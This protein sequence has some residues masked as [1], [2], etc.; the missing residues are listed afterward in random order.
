MIS[1]D[2]VPT[3]EAAKT[4]DQFFEPGG[5]LEQHCTAGGI[6]YELRPQQ[7]KM[8][9]AIADAAGFGHHLAVEAGTGVGK[10]FAYLVPQ[11]LSALEHETRCVIATYTITL[12]EQ[13][14]HKDIP[15]VRQV[16]GREFK[17]V[18]VKGRSNYLCLLRLQR[19]RR[20]GSDLFDSSK[21]S[22]L[23]AIYALASNRQLGDGSLQELAEQPDHQVWG[24]ICAEHG[25][26]TGKRCPFYKECYFMNA[27]QAMMDAQVL[28][29][30]HSLFFAELAL[31]AEGAAML[32]PYG[33]VVF[34][35]AHQMEQVASS[36]LGIRLSLYMLEYWLRRIYIADKNKGLCAVLKDGKGA[37]LATQTSEAA[38]LFF[39]NVRKHFKLGA[40]KT[41]QCVAEP[42]PIDTDLPLKIT[43]LCHHLQTLVQTTDNE[44]IQAEIKSSRNRGLELR[45]TVEAF[46][47]QSLEGQVYWVELQGRNKQAVLYSAP[48]DV[49]PILREMLFEEI[50]C[51]V[52]TSATLAVGNNLEYFRH[53]IGAEECAE[54]QV[55]SPFD[56]SRQMKIQLPTN[57]PPPAAP[58]FEEAA[59]TAIRHFVGESR[60]RAFVLFTNA[61]FMKKVADELRFGFEL[62]GFEFLVQGA[63]MPPQLMLEKFRNHD[64]AV[65]FGLDRFWMGVD[66]QGEALSN[67]IITRLPF[68]VPDHPLIQ[69]RFEAIEARGGNPFK[70]YSLPEAVL[71]FRQGVGRLIRS[72][73]DHGTV[74]ILDSRIRNQWYGR[75]FL[76]SIDECPVEDVEVPGIG[77]SEG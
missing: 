50:P 46:L 77:T 76:E 29:V 62:D 36:H 48:V 54:L 24:A 10:S 21:E 9:R 74:T 58:N 18:M 70:D 69:A 19:A 28:V 38:E 32:P 59:T 12:Q 26:C 2:P 44:D 57:M 49:G 68:A 43:N 31:R 51:V 6:N 34:D 14:M 23:D 8:A 72:T 41:Q 52:M 55:G 75:L 61:R 4:T 60:G 7:Q 73:N 27:R 16:L 13:L 35:E 17:A 65:L 20:S 67:V 56:Y 45:D 42:P 5:L 11:I 22:Q 71:K 47:K 1:L 64:A 37:L 25:N 33:Y 15:F 63:G 40:Q 66:V 30:N 3:P 53:R 39:E